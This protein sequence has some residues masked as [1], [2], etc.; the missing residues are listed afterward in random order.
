MPADLDHRPPVD[1]VLHAQLRRWVARS[2]ITTEEAEAIEA[3]ERASAPTVAAEPRR[4]PLLTEALVY[5]GAALAAA[6]AV[7]LLADRWE[8]LRSAVRVAAVGAACIVTLGAGLLLRRSS[9]PAMARVT[10]VAWFVAVGLFGWM[11]W[12]VAYDL[13]ELRGRVP[14]LIAGVAVTVLG[15]ALYAQLRRGLQQFAMVA[16]LMTVAGASVGE[17]TG[18]MLAVWAVA[19][20]WTLVGVLGLL[21]PER[22][23]LVGGPAVAI[24]S[25]LAMPGD[26]GMWLGLATGVALIVVGVTRREPILLGFGAF[27]VFVHLLRLLGRFFAGTAVM[28]IALLVAG[29]VVLALAVLYARRSGRGPTRTAP[30]SPS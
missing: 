14:A 24:W 15:G 13:L 23:A 17:G 26:V 6:A 21:Q 25:P 7:V 27:G 28:P 19:V 8:D 4:M 11:T 18:A 20:A 1:P 22:A 10:S 12:L 2:L 5:V 29:A 16:G 9:D 3:F 30:R